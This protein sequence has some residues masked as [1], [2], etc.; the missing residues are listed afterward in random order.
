LDKKI[1]NIHKIINNSSKLKLKINI[2]TKG[3]SRKQIIISIGN[4]NKLKFISFLSMYITNI[5]SMFKA[6]KSNIIAKF[7][8][9]E[10]Q[11]IIITINKVTSSLNLQ[12]IEN[13]TIELSKVVIL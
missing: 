11:S 4:N 8:Y 6:I 10:Q 2:T 9:I 3:F 1:K 13:Y 5:N 7:V 12:T